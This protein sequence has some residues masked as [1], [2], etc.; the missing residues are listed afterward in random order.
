M[1]SATR[2][3]GATMRQTRVL[4]ADDNDSFGAVLGRF[5]AVH[6]DMVVVGRASSGQEAVAMTD[7]LMPDVVLMDL[8]MTGM[9]GFEATRVLSATHPEVKVVAITAHR[10]AE[11]ER[12]SLEAGAR[13]F[14]NKTDADTLLI[15]VIRGLAGTDADLHC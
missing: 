7:A 1:F 6:G 12:L 14:L 3:L 2:L 8:Y 5:V 11:T 13:A 9:D 10:S 15:D 4:V